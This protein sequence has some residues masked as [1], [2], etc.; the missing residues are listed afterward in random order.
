MALN[1]A[2]AERFRLLAYQDAYNSLS[3]DI[4][5]IHFPGSRHIID[6]PTPDS[7]NWLRADLN[8][9]MKNGVV[10][11]KTRIERLAPTTKGSAQCRSLTIMERRWEW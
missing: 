7:A 10:T 6:A 11:D 1:R 8:G 5:C 4:T 3:H 9:P 2:A